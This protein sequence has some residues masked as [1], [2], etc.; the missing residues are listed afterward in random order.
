MQ[1]AL[2]QEREQAAAE[3]GQLRVEQE[4]GAGQ[5]AA[6]G[7]GT[8]AEQGGIG[9]QIAGRGL[10]REDAQH[11]L[12]VQRSEPHDLAPRA[13]GW[14]LPFERGS[15]QDDDRSVGRLLQCLEKAV[16]RL[17]GEMIGIEDDRHLAAA[18]R[19]L[20]EEPPAQPLAHAVLAVADEG[21]QRNRRPVSRLRHDVDVGMAAAVRLHAGSALAAG[22][23]SGPG[24]LAEQRLRQRDS[25]PCSC[26]RRQ[27][28]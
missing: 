16:G 20:Q 1:R 28:R 22:H 17:V 14:Q 13:D 3:C 11:R 6:G 2:R 24:P 9:R 25:P 5:T 15:H 27:V 18:E 10:R 21:L 7:G 26:P 23:Q 8:A 12:L 19:R 4:A